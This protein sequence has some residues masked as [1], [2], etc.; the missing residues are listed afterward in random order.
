MVRCR[1]NVLSLSDDLDCS[2]EEFMLI[3]D[4]NIFLWISIYEIQLFFFLLL[5]EV[6]RSSPQAS[7]D[8]SIS[9]ALPVPVSVEGGGSKGPLVKVGMDKPKEGKKSDDESKSVP[10][11]GEAREDP[12]LKS[13]SEHRTEASGADRNKERDRGRGSERDRVKARN[14]GRGRD[15]DREREREE[16]DRDRDIVKDRDQRS[17]DRAKDSGWFLYFFMENL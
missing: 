11:E 16:I 14:R 2:D 3:I 1:N 8:A 17:K 7:A 10:S 5:Q 15:S 4:I 6:L 12:M 13:R 9:N